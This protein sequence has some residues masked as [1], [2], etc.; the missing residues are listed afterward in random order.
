[1]NRNTYIDT[2]YTDSLKLPKIELPDVLVI[3]NGLWKQEESKE[4]IYVEQVIHS[5]LNS[6]IEWKTT[7]QETRERSFTV[8][9]GEEGMRQFNQAIEAYVS[10]PVQNRGQVPAWRLLDEETTA[11]SDSVTVN[12]TVWNSR[13]VGRSHAETQWAAIRDLHIPS[14]LLHE[15]PQPIAEI[16]N[17]LETP[18]ERQRR[19]QRNS[20]T[21]EP[22]EAE[23]IQLLDNLSNETNDI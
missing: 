22:T 15:P 4:K 6:P 18:R 12:S 13:R 1:M 10:S 16:E 19:R 17:E 8:F 11:N 23:L 20:T 21:T 5:S 3:T 2:D 7:P 9:A 14:E